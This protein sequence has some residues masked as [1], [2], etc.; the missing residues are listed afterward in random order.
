[1]PRQIWIF[2]FPVE[3]PHSFGGV[4]GLLRFI[5]DEI[6]TSEFCRLRHSLFRE[7]TD[8]DI[9]ILCQRAQLYEHFE[10]IRW[11]EPNVDD[12]RLF[13]KVGR[14]YIV[15]RTALYSSPVALSAVGVQQIRFGKDVSNETFK[16]IL[17]LRADRGILRYRAAP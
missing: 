2:P 14:V 12:R 5:T 4:A 16:R 6:F 17:G 1:M 8:G 10:L 3:T 15:R 13:P 11:E 7:P 9:I